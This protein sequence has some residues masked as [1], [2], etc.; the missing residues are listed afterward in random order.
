[1][2]KISVIVT[3]YNRKELL[4]ETINSIINQT[5]K[6]FELIVVDNNSNYNFLSEIKSF[7]DER[8]VAFQNNNNGIIARNRN[9]GIMKSKGEFIAF[10]D[11]DDLWVESKLEEQI[12]LFD[13]NENLGLV[14]S[15]CSIFNNGSNKVQRISPKGS[16]YNGESFNKMIFIMNVPFSTTLVRKSVFDK[17][18]YFDEYR[19]LLA[20]EDKSFWIRLSSKYL[21]ASINRPL[22]YYRIHKKNT[23][24][25]NIWIH[26]RKNIFLFKNL[27]NKGVLTLP[28]LLFIAMPGLFIGLLYHSISNSIRIF[29]SK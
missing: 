23:S 26:L 2:P 18:G 29:F 24:D 3:T 21:I 14:Y 22:I 12:S 9:F 6:D 16:L 5:F 17:I 15:K 25:E 8:I 19:D 13:S 7:D 28:K 27:Y 1:M 10:C 4:K 20:K 11:D